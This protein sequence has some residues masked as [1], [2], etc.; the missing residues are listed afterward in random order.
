MYFKKSSCD[1]RANIRAAAARKLPV[2]ATSSSNCTR[3]GPNTTFRPHITRS[4]GNADA[5][6]AP[7]FFAF[8]TP[9][10]CHKTAP[11]ESQF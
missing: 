3:P 8:A 10:T 4:R 7:L 11:V 6:N 2:S 1:Q 9:D 5:G